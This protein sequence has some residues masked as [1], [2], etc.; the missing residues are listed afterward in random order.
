MS[1]PEKLAAFTPG[2]EMPMWQF[3]KRFLATVCGGILPRYGQATVRIVGVK[4][5]AVTIKI[6]AKEKVE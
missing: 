6:T 5:G 1:Q 3:D 4:D 2:E